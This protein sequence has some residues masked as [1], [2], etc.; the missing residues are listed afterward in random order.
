LLSSPAGIERMVKGGSTEHQH[1]ASAVARPAHT[2]ASEPSLELLDSAFDGAR[3][4]GI[5]FFAKLLILHA[6]LMNAE[7]ASVFWQVGTF[8]FQGNGSGGTKE[9]VIE[10][11]SVPACSTIRVQGEESGRSERQMLAGME[12]INNLEAVREW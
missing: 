3:A 7:I 11:M 2:S 12:P 9:E 6:T 5:A 1:L 10:S 4:N 8:E